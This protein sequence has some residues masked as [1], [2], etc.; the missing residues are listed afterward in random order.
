MTS[1]QRVRILA[2]GCLA[3]LGVAAGTIALVRSSD[4]GAQSS[5]E[6]FLPDLVQVA[7]DQISVQRARVHGQ[8]AWRLIFRSAVEIPIDQGRLVLRGHRSSRRTPFLRVDQY[9]DYRDPQSGDIVSQERIRDVGRMRYVY[10]RDH[11]HFHY[12]GFDRYELRRVKDGRRVTRDRKS[13][14][15]LGD[16]YLA[17]SLPARSASVHGA[18][19]VSPTAH[20]IRNSQLDQDCRSA[21]PRRLTVTEGITPGNGDDYKPSLEG[22]FL[23]ITD[24]RPG[25][26][27]LVHRANSDRKLHEVRFSNDVSSALIVLRRPSDGAPTIH[28]LKRCTSTARC[29]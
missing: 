29:S 21:E 18:Q 13:G 7:P 12:L 9:I 25:R 16:R 20:V 19:R 1:I 11:E 6:P 8:T 5:P 23:D 28:V 4:A 27:W 10:S 15:C 17:G 14:F 22:Q 3:C 24:V 26:Y 2:A